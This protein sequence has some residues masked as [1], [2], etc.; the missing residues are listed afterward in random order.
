MSTL[1]CLLVLLALWLPA[2]AAAAPPNV[3]MI[4]GDDQGWT[5]FGFM[6][7]KIVKTPHL[8]KLASA[9]AVFP[10]GY[11]AEA[12]CTHSHQA[13]LSGLN[14]RDVVPKD[15]G[16]TCPILPQLLQEL[17]YRT[18]GQGKWW[19]EGFSSFFTH[20]KD[21]NLKYLHFARE[22]KRT[23]DKF[24]DETR[25]FWDTGKFPTA[26]LD[27]EK[28]LNPFLTFLGN[29]RTPTEPWFYWCAPNL[30]HHPFEGAPD[31]FRKHYPPELPIDD[32]QL[33]IGEGRAR[34]YF[35]NVSWLDETV[36]KVLWILEQGKKR[37][38]IVN[39]T[40]LFFLSDNGAALDKSKGQFTES[41]TR[42]P[43]LV[44][45]P[46]RIDAKRHK[47]SIGEIDILK[48]ILDYALGDSAAPVS[49]RKDRKPWMDAVSLKRVIEKPAK[50]AGWLP[51]WR[52]H[53]FFGNP[54]DSK[55]FSVR[56]AHYKLYTGR[57]PQDRK[58]F[59]LEA[60]EHGPADEFET[61][62]LLDAKGTP[63]TTEAQVALTRLARIVEL[64]SQ[65][66]YEDLEREVR[67][68]FPA[69]MAAGA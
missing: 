20:S 41:G 12:H 61:K 16:T 22:E 6:G 66:K 51:A 55:E 43:I 56:D 2:Q 30:P 32:D 65:R 48:T 10:N 5:D 3:V 18:C 62:N 21:S 57:K 60:N 7:H 24:T 15:L 17:G 68:A 34:D 27:P 13:L 31:R 33:A 4:V 44:N 63:K 11:V 53:V 49:P 67:T 52:E 39:D 64:W 40:L 59:R 25:A 29:G 28:G 19:I 54:T 42:T 9:S 36:G 58:L 1:R 46:E 35:T 37:Q 8:D 38:K 23:F 14:L 47:E 26:G 50:N 45:C 69:A